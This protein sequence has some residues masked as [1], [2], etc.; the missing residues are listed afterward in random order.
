M[1]RSLAPIPRGATIVEGAGPITTFF[2]LR[3]QELIDA[4]LQSSS[5]A[6]VTFEQKTDAIPT[7]T[8]FVVVAPGRYRIGWYLRETV[9]DGV[10]SSLIVTLG[11]TDKGSA[12]TFVG[13]ALTADSPT[14]FQTGTIEVRSDAN[15]DLTVAI[16][17]A[18]NTPNRLTFDAEFTVEF[19]P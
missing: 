17:Y 5:V 8:L 10:S 14:A 7:A 6:A 16:A 12:L 9:N 4:F 13:P 15:V 19:L 2:R 11:F 1:P 3:W 18:S